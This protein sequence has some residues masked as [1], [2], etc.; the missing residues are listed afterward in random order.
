MRK[1]LVSLLLA[2]SVFA[3]EPLMDGKL[4][5]GV[6]MG[7]K[8][9]PLPLLVEVD[10][11]GCVV[12]AVAV[13]GG[14]RRVLIRPQRIYCGKDIK[15]VSGFVTDEKGILGLRC[16]RKSCILEKGTKVKVFIHESYLEDFL[17]KI[18]SSSALSMSAAAS[19]LTGKS[20]GVEKDCISEV[21][22]NLYTLKT[23]VP[24]W[25]DVQMSLM[26]MLVSRGTDVCQAFESVTGISLE[27]ERNVADVAEKFAEEWKEAVK[28]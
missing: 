14:G 21:L 23:Y 26:K 19:M 10:K 17:K 6:E 8:K 9:E 1:V 22:A 13:H 4:L 27:Q 25:A 3:Q 20:S 16:G 7:N 5:T 2:G 11:S 15:T 12:Y 18:F 24:Y 28:R